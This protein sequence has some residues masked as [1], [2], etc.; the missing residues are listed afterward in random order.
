MLIRENE[1]RDE[2]YGFFLSHDSVGLFIPWTRF[3]SLSLDG[4]H[5]M[6]LHMLVHNPASEQASERASECYL[7]RHLKSDHET[8]ANLR[9]KRPQKLVLNLKLRVHC[10]CFVFTF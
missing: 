3:C 9:Q 2:K 5:R 1:R 4:T 6:K 7:L 8:P 10:S